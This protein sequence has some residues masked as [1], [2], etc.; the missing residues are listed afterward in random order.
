MLEFLPEMIKNAID[1][2]NYN[3]IYEIRMRENQPIMVNYFGKYR[4]LGVR[5]LTER[6]ENA[7]R[8]SK[9]DIDACIYKAGK[10]SVYSIEEQIKKG[11]LT[12]GNGERIGIVGEYVFD[13]GQPLTIRNF[14]SVCIRVPHEIVGAGEQIYNRCMCDKV[15]NVLI[16]SPPGLGKTTILR[17]LGRIL[18]NKTQKN[19]LICDERGEIC[20]GE[21][22]FTSDI[23]KFAEKRYAFENGI[24]AMRPDIIITDELSEI[25]CESVKK[26]IY[27][28]IIVIASA[29]FA[30]MESISG[31][32]RGLFDYYVLLN[33]TEIGKIDRI[34]QKNGTEWAEC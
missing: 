16:M 25:D 12:A 26:A 17:D 20:A 1:F 5:G 18:S 24:R 2:L 8:C 33:T 4:F 3:L 19:I 28:G 31:I 34:Y 22:G 23:M 6:A 11:F 7:I 30:S 15:N 32:F 9:E 29:H 10:Y 13:K 21:L 14:S 27:A